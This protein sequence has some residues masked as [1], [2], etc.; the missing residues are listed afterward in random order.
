ML[1][2]L[3]NMSYSVNMVN[4]CLCD[5]ETEAATGDVQ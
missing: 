4:Y 2:S 5:E 1:E 3:V